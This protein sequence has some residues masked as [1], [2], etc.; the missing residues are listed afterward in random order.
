MT[1]AW[2]PFK[3]RLFGHDPDLLLEATNLMKRS[4]AGLISYDDFIKSISNL[5]SMAIIDTK[6][7][8]E[9][10]VANEELFLFIEELKKD[11]RI[12]LLSNASDDW[13]ADMFTPEQIAVFDAVALS[14]EMGHIKPDK[15][16]YMV[17]AERLGVDAGNCVFVDDQELYCTGAREVGMKAIWYQDV[18]Q[19]RA[20]LNKLLNA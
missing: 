14:Y 12:G 6:K 20:E 4:D 1:D 18:E 17:I 3:A 7:A 16:A 2:L 10:N 5:A 19:T 15:R 9:D 11:Y 13:L 8:I